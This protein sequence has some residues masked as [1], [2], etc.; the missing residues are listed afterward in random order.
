MTNN[1]SPL[2]HLA[3][4]EIANQMNAQLHTS[5]KTTPWEVVFRQKKPINWLTAQERRE[6]EGVE[7][8]GGGIITEESLS[9]ELEGEEDEEVLTGFRE[10]GEFL[11]IQVPAPGSTIRVQE[12][13]P[14][15]AKQPN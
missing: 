2:W 8:E 7:V 3:L 6:A 4:T 15:L 5:L 14:G 13:I 1:R 9:K 11:N 12:G 10:I